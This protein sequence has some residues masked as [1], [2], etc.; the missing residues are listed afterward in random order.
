M[1]R[2]ARVLSIDNVGLESG[3]KTLSLHMPFV[4]IGLYEQG[5][6]AQRPEPVVLSCGLGPVG[7]CDGGNHARIADVDDT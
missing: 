1:F 7:A 4:V 6:A 3:C 5:V 2:K